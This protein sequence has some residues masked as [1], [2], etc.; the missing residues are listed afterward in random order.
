M[1]LGDVARWASA[2]ARVLDEPSVARTLAAA[3]RVRA[4]TFT[5]DRAAEALS[6]GYRAALG[7]GET[8]RR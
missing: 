6:A 2:L 4:A 1:T 3:G 5:W 7:V 8:G